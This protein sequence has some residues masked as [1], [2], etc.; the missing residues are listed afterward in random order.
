MTLHIVQTCAEAVGG[1][2]GITAW[3]VERHGCIETARRVNAAPTEPPEPMAASA[4]TDS[5][6]DHGHPTPT[7][8][9]IP[10]LKPDAVTGSAVHTALAGRRRPQDQG[11]RTENWNYLGLTTLHGASVATAAAAW[12]QPWRAAASF[13]CSARTTARDWLASLA[14]RGP[15]AI[16]AGQAYLHV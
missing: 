8:P 5:R 7:P 16:A 2:N 15:W 11:P 6:V 4:A 14:D 9:A 12:V 10:Q 13:C 3:L 1:P